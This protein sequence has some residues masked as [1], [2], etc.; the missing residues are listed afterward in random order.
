MDDQDH[1]AIGDDTSAVDVDRWYAMWRAG[2]VSADEVLAVLAGALVLLDECISSVRQRIA[3]GEQ[4]AYLREVREEL[5]AEYTTRTSQVTEVIAAG[6]VGEQVSFW[7]GTTCVGTG[8][9]VAMHERTSACV[10]TVGDAL[11]AA[12][13]RHYT[14]ALQRADGTTMRVMGRTSELHTIGRARQAVH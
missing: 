3:A 11:T 4:G 8:A 9:I 1:G 10:R 14:V 5:A 13:A 6:R 12:A 2:D 7:S